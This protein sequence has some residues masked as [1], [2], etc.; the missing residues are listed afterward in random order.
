MV[1]A[2]FREGH[3]LSSLPHSLPL[4]IASASATVTKSC[5]LPVLSRDFGWDFLIQQLKE[6]T[7]VAVGRWG[8]MHRRRLGGGDVAFIQGPARSPMW[9][10]AD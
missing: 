2:A 3:A 6:H 10:V 9:Q 8:K 4:P 5:N 1:A 7:V